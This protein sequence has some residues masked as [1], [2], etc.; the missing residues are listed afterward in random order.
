MEYSK[1]FKLMILTVGLLS[2]AGCGSSSSSPSEVKSDVTKEISTDSFET[3][4]GVITKETIIVVGESKDTETT[5]K[6]SEGTQFVDSESGEV[7][8]E[9]PRVHV[10]T[11]KSSQESL[12]TIIFETSDGKKVIPSEPITV[13]VPAP[14]GAKPGDRVQIKVPDD[15]GIKAAKINQKL[16]IA[17]V[18]SDGTIEIVIDPD[19]FKGQVIIII[20]FEE[21]KKPNLD[22]STN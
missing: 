16:I 6:I 22:E 19:Q 8:T 4:T 13:S 18:K 14:A 9:V 12:T 7:I 20:I 21:E 17:I 5:I 11:T 10:T 1:I 3:T 2:L 15:G